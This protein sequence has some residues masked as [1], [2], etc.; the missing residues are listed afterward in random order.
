MAADYPAF[1]GLDLTGLGRQI[2][3]EKFT[4]ITLTNETDPRTVLFV[5]GDQLMLFGNLSDLGFF[6]FTNRKQCP[7]EL[8]LAQCVEKVTLV[9]PGIAAFQ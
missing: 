7:G 5:V 1:G 3:A 8:V 2:A 4:K 6:Q 9:F